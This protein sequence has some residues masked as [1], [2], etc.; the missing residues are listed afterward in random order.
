MLARASLFVG[1]DSGPTHLSAALGRPT[2][3]IFGPTDPQLT[4]P[5]GGSSA[6]VYKNLPCGP[7]HDQAAECPNRKCLLSITPEEVAAEALGVVAQAKPGGKVRS[8]RYRDQ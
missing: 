7:C 5:L 6:V 8:V 4:G 2:L 1:Q 3:A